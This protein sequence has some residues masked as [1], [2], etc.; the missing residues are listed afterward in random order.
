MNVPPIMPIILEEK[1]ASHLRS[2]GICAYV[3]AG[4]ECLMGLV[5]ILYMGIGLWIALE[6]NEPSGWIFFGVGLLL[7]LWIIAMTVLTILSARWMGQ[8]KRWTFCLVISCIH[9]ISFPFGLA[10]GIFSIIVLVRPSVK[11]WFQ[12]REGQ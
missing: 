11:N 10:L 4:L 5:A 6:Q 2:L 7:G 9:C 12:S 3:Y 8:G 1:D